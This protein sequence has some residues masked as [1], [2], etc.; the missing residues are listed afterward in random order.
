VLRILGYQ[1]ICD[2]L[3]LAYLARDYIV[4]IEKIK[5]GAKDFLLGE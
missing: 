3:S 4:T 5:E 1:I 2:G